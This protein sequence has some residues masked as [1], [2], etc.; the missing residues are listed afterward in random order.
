MEFPHAHA[1]IEEVNVIA[2]TPK[3]ATS[4]EFP[5]A[6][7]GSSVLNRDFDVFVVEKAEVERKLPQS[8]ESVIINLSPSLS[9]PVSDNATWTQNWQSKS[10]SE[11]VGGNDIKVSKGLISKKSKEVVDDTSNKN[12]GNV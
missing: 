11:N 3:S 4:L 1:S 10:P 8:E 5:Y 6:H 9:P 2:L 7:S 12:H